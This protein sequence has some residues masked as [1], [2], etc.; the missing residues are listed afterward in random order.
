MFLENLSIAL[1]AILANKMR[2]IL[3]VLGVMIGV[4]AVIAVVSIVQGLQY[5]IAGDLND[6]GSNFIQVFPD[7]GENRNPMLQRTPDLTIADAAAVRQQT[8]AIRAFSPIFVSQAQARAGEATHSM[9]LYA[10]SASYQDILNHW[11]EHGRFFTPVD[12]EQK[13]R[14]CTIG[15]TAAEELNLGNDPLGKVIRINNNSFTV[16]GVMEKKGG[17]FGNNQDDVVLIPFATATVLYGSDT[18]RRLVLAF[19]M[20]DGADLELAKDQVREVLRA[21]HHLKK[22]DRDDFRIIAQ[23]EILKTVSKVLLYV[24]LML[25][26]AVG[27]ALL[28]GGVGIMNIMLVSVTERTREIGIRKAI[29]ARRIDIMVQFLIE[30]ITLAALG[31]VVGIVGGWLLANVGRWVISRWTDL[32]PVHTPL[33]AVL[34]ATGFCALLGVLFGM[35]PAV[36]ASKLDPIDALRYE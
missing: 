4:A 15:I 9:Q 28:V 18:M 5:K 23:E 25:G 20:R 19:Q 26:G 29:G 24:T 17:S 1:R 13:K 14:V 33:W 36:R 7:A 35:L 6:I 32:P 8:T 12:E 10:V 3:T 11:V 27:I 2:S 21:R 22:D 16:V 34:I 31:G 30:A